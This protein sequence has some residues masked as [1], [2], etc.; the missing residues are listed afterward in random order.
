M[1]RVLDVGNCSADHATIRDVVET[2][3]DAKVDSADNL[4][5][6]MVKLTTE[7]YDLVLVNRIMDRD[8]SSGLEIINTIKQDDRFREVPVMLITNYDE[9]QQ[10][11]IAAGAVRGFG[12]SSVDS[13]ETARLLKSHL[14]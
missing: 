12:K 2:H 9:Y 11:A 8:G 10:K 5:Q 6:T 7:T 14:T 1:K 4:A 13:N 3:C